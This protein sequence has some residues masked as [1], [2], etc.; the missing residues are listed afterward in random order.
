M[1]LLEIVDGYYSKKRPVG[2]GGAAWSL[3][4][5]DLLPINPSSKPPNFTPISGALATAPQNLICFAPII[6]A[7]LNDTI[8]FKLEEASSRP[9]HCRDRVVAVLSKHAEGSPKRQFN[10][11]NRRWDI[12]KLRSGSGSPNDRSF[13]LSGGKR[14]FHL[15]KYASPFIHRGK[16]HF[17]GQKMG[18]LQPCLDQDLQFTQN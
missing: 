14:P 9:P 15:R 13:F 16:M 7:S 2:H 12:A 4:I 11:R 8:V 10:A 3:P 18:K 6:P 5:F 17:D 1:V